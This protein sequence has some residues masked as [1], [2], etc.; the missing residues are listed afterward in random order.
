M[1]ESTVKKIIFFLKEYFL[2][3]VNEIEILKN[4]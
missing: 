3:L 1:Y 4:N 2:T